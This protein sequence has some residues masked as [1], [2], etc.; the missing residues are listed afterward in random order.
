MKLVVTMCEAGFTSNEDS[1]DEFN[2]IEETINDIEDKSCALLAIQLCRYL[3]PRTPVEKAPEIS[4]FLLNHLD[5]RQ[6]QHK[7]QMTCALSSY[8]IWSPEILFSTTNQE[9]LNVQLKNR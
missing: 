1:D 2:Q 5:E 8:V 9:I 4:D 3:N 6:F 7:C